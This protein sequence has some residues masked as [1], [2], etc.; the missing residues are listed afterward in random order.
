MDGNVS[1]TAPNNRAMEVIDRI[2]KKLIGQDFGKEILDHK[3]QVNR[4]IE[5]ATSETNL[6]LLFH[7]FCPWW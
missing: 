5:E 2:Q 4:L 1:G 3:S 7:G 6:A